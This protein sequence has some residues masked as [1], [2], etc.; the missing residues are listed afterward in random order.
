MAAIR[1]ENGD[2]KRDTHNRR[3]ACVAPLSRGACAHRPYAAAIKMKPRNRTQATLFKRHYTSEWSPRGGVLRCVIDDDGGDDGS[4]PVV[5]VDDR[6][7]DWEDFG[8]LIC[9]YA[10]WGMRI[11]FVPD[12][13][14]DRTP[15][16]VVREPDDHPFE[17]E[18]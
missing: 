5:H 6:E 15:K 17:K 11:V 7:F 16:I 4:L 13:E 2:G 10:G 8:R 14:L 9:T 12:D 3:Q 1:T 18:G